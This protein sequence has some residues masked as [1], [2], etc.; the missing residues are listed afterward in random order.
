MFRVLSLLLITFSLLVS[1]SVRAATPSKPEMTAVDLFTGARTAMTQSDPQTAILYLNTLLN[2]PQN[3]YTQE[4]QELIGMAREDARQTDKARAEYESYL[5][6]YPTGVNADRVRG[7]LAGLD[8]NVPKDGKP[9]E[10]KKK[11]IREIRQ[12][13]TNASVSQYYYGGATQSPDG[14]K[15]DVSTLITNVEASER[16]KFYEWD[17]KLVFRDTQIHNMRS[18]SADRNNVQSFYLEQTNIDE[19]YMWRVGRQTSVGQ[20]VLGRFDGAT[21]KYRISDDFRLTGVIGVP[22][23]GSHHSTKTD[24]HF[25]G[26]GIELNNPN[27][28]WSGN[29]YIMQQVADGLVERRSL[30]GEARYFN[31]DTFWLASLDYDTIYNQTTLA[32][33]Q[34]SVTVGSYT[35]NT[36]LDHRNSTILGAEYAISSVVGALSVSDLRQR[37]SSGEIYNLVKSVV[38]QTDTAMFGITKDFGEYW[39]LSGD[40]RAM[41]I[42]STDGNAV[43]AA[44]P[45]MKDNYTFTFQ[46]VGTGIVWGNDTFILMSSHVED[47]R[48]TANNISVT[49]SLPI[50]QWHLTNTIRYY[51]EN[52]GLGLGS[53]SVNPVVRLQYQLQPNMSVEAE[54]NINRTHSNDGYT[55]WREML[56]FGYRWDLR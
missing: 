26:A 5:R 27:Y 36:L 31:G 50:D 48:Y 37:L 53:T 24:R 52:Q 7:R 2:M 23:E 33:L 20:G 19:D 17:T 43:I 6:M 16:Y 10:A 46:A 34:G 21:G 11:P 45:E 3:E 35:F 51:E 28:Q 41:Y 13:T 1:T 54:L 18:G 55:T 15:V 29:A 12:A 56:F 22:D 44:Q 49:H 8:K 32:M 40:V 25:Y 4:A 30:G 42:G 9:A 39:K 38:P 47:P 14:S